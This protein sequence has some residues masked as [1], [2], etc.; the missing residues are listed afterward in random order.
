MHKIVRLHDC[1]GKIQGLPDVSQNG[2]RHFY[3]YLGIP[4][5]QPPVGKLRS[6]FIGIID[7]ILHNSVQAENKFFGPPTFLD[8]FDLRK[9]LAGHFFPSGIVFTYPQGPLAL[10]S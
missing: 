1:A 5:A 7:Y 10:G 2:K 4:Y 3:K 8:A 9:L 6:V